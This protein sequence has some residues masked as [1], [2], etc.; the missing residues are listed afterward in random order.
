M[1]RIEGA[2]FSVVGMGKS[3]LAA[4]NLLARM[5]GDVLLSD[6]RDNAELRLQATERADPK[7]HLAF[8]GETIRRGDVAILSPGI[9]PSA[10]AFRDAYRLAS[11]VIGEVELFFRLIPGRILAVTGTD[12]KSTTTTLAAHLLNEAGIP[13]HPAGNLGNPLCDLIGSIADSDVVVAEVSCYQLLTTDRFRP[14]VAL[15]TNL[16]E[17]H[18]EHHG[19]FAAYVAA[20]ARVLLRQ[21][22]GD[23]FVRNL[24]DGLLANWLRPGDPWTSDN[25]QH[26]QDIS[27]SG[28]VSDGAFL[29]D[30]GLFLAAGGHEQRVASRAAFALP[31]EHNTENVL[32]ALAAT[33]ALGATPEG[34]GRG[35]GTYRGLPHRIEKIRVLD[36]VTFYN[37]S[38]AT[39]PHAA[40]TG[41]RAFDRG[42][43]LMAG[44][45]EKGLALTDLAV[46][47]EQRCKAVVLT[48]DCAPRMKRE[49][50]RAVPCEV[51]DDLESAVIRAWEL[52]RPDGIVLFSPAASSFDRY[53]SFEQRG[54]CFRNLVNGL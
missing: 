18:L 30:G 16:A 47:I 3:G 52:A 51:V 23:V 37:D 28:P 42:V 39:N 45:F 22:H 14:C 11:E 36:G 4:A 53:S 10:T 32:L 21:S 1:M 25:G 41:L 20:K 46:E 48:G 33:A 24:D 2:A 19:S 15:V 40:I 8:G 27:R 6:G 7:V 9:P 17:D 43:V 38:K 50:P 13:A 29:L 5:G 44:G 34:L 49:F 35:L 54:D 12:G 26:V 31:G